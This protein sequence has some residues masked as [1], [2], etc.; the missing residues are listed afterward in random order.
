MHRPELT[1]PLILFIIILYGIF[2]KTYIFTI[3]VSTD[4]AILVSAIVQVRL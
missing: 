1:F 3:C 4:G 2:W